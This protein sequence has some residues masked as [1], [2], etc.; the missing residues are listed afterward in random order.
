[1]KPRQFVA[2]STATLAL[3]AFLPCHA[4]DGN[5]QSA[6]S[7]LS[8]KARDYATREDKEGPPDVAAASTASVAGQKDGEKMP[9]LDSPVVDKA[10]RDT[11]DNWKKMDKVLDRF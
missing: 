5:K 4:E 11:G 2:A 9:V 1:M 10:A 7:R 6:A 8:S 3:L